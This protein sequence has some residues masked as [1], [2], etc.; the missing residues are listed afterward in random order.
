MVPRKIKVPPSQKEPMGLMPAHS[1]HDA[2]EAIG[3]G[4]KPYQN[5]EVTGDVVRRGRAAK[6]EIWEEYDIPI[7]KERVAIV[8]GWTKDTSHGTVWPVGAGDIHRRGTEWRTERQPHGYI[9]AFNAYH[10]D[11]GDPGW[12]LKDTIKHELAH[13]INWHLDGYTVEGRGI[14]KTWCLKLDAPMS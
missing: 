7:P 10:Y 3:G 13:A 6:R 11:G 2:V 5:I 1:V 4:A 9:I 12:S 14:H 8:K